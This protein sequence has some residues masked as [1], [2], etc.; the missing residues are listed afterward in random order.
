MILFSRAHGRIQVQTTMEQSVSGPSLGSAGPCAKD[1]FSDRK[2]LRCIRG[3]PRSPIWINAVLTPVP[4]RQAVVSSFLVAR[5]APRSPADLRTA[6]G[7]Q[8]SAQKYA[9]I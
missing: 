5:Q 6:R 9:S 4:S 3:D 1:L 8:P 2:P 7:K